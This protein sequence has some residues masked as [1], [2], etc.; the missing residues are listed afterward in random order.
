MLLTFGAFLL[1]VIEVDLFMVS[2]C[3]A[4]PTPARRG[5]DGPG[6]SLNSFPLPAGV[7][8]PSGRLSSADAPLNPSQRAFVRRRQLAEE[9]QSMSD[10]ASMEKAPSNGEHL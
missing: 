6:R 8:R 3:E 7:G 5:R 1:S 4:T 2:A 10:A 9:M